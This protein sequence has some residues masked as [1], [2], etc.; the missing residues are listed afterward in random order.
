[1]WK[2]RRIDHDEATKQLR[3]DVYVHKPALDGAKKI[4][5]FFERDE[6]GSS[7][8]Q[9]INDSIKPIELDDQDY[10]ILYSQCQ[11]DD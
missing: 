7:P 1:M 5:I 9:S 4:N 3:G 6:Y 2:L 11:Q 10:S 8:I